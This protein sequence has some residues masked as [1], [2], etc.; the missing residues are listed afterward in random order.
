M[1]SR[2]EDYVTITDCQSA[3]LSIVMDKL[4]RGL[5]YLKMIAILERPTENGSLR[6]RRG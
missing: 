3:A 5:Y 2:I 1:P 4:I 6:Q